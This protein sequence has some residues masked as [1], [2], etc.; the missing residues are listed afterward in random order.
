[1]DRNDAVSVIEKLIETCRD[2]Q[3]GY[4]DA[5]EHVKRPDLKSFF[6]QQSAERGRFAEE[7]QRE[8]SSLGESDKKPSGS[9]VGALHRT[10][11][12]AK[13]TLG[14]GD[15]TILE[16]VEQG[17]DSAKA[18]YE[19]ALS[20]H[21]PSNLQTIVQ[22]QAQSVKSAHDKVRSMRDSLAA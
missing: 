13:A 9:V 18:A 6:E 7:L 21:L 1:M 16:S 14:G 2:G 4:A 19:E 20:S 17:E 5:A 3:K 22:R 11:I 15:K 12:D 8:L 10:W